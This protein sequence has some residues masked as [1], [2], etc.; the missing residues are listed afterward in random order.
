MLVKNE[1]GGAY[2]GFKVMTVEPVNRQSLL[3]RPPGQ[4]AVPY[5]PQWAA[6]L[7]VELPRTQLPYAPGPP[8]GYQTGPR[9]APQQEEPKDEAQEWRPGQIWSRT[10]P[11]SPPRQDPPPPRRAPRPKPDD[12]DDRPGPPP[13]FGRGGDR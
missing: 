12:A 3:E 2:G 10:P 11:K 9:P 13:L 7:P 6:P 5:P 8:P 4:G 1:R